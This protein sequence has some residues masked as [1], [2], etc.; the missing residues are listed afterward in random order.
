MIGPE[1]KAVQAGP[2]HR[3]CI[4]PSLTEPRDDRGFSLVEILVVV[5]ILGIIGTVS[6][7]AVR[8]HERRQRDVACTEDRRIITTAAES[9]FAQFDESSI[10]SVDPIVPGRIGVNPEATLVEVGLSRPSELHDVD[11]DGVV[12]AQ[13]GSECS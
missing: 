13:A 10:P 12:T 9:Y 11:A 3:A 7:F 6:V 4:A 2:K 1:L 8:R 5:V